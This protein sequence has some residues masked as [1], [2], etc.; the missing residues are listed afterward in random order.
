M[1][2]LRMQRRQTCSNIFLC[3]AWAHRVIVKETE[4]NERTW[5]KERQAKVDARAKKS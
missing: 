3:V 4:S 2:V 1:F 5:E